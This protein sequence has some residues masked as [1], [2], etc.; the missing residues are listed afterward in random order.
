MYVDRTCLPMDH[1]YEVHFSE[2]MVHIRF[3]AG[4]VIQP[5]E[6]PLVAFGQWAS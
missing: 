3:I 5:L 1:P 4:M 2:A 6:Q